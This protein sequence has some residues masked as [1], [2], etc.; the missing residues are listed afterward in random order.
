M[1]HTQS[2]WHTQELTIQKCFQ[3][4]AS[5]RWVTALSGV[6][7]VTDQQGFPRGLH[8]DY[9]YRHVK[10]LLPGTVLTVHTRLAAESL[11][12]RQLQH[13]DP[14]PSQANRIRAAGSLS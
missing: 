4:K 8:P 3:L 6:T 10:E 7:Q 11:P 12:A 2:H 5:G 9:G 13:E 14:D 1:N